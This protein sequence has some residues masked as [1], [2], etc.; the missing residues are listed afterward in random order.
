MTMFLINYSFAY[1][2]KEKRKKQNKQKPEETSQEGE[3]HSELIDPFN[4]ETHDQHQGHYFRLFDF[5]R[6]VRLIRLYLKLGIITLPSIM[7]CFLF[8]NDF[9]HLI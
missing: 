8:M 2:E 9:F 1:H 3:H 7:S 5:W 6:K 4:Y